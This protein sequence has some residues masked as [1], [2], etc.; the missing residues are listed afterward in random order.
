MGAARNQNKLT[1]DGIGDVDT[2]N[3]GANSHRQSRFGT[4]VSS[5]D[6]QLPGG[7]W[8]IVEPQISVV[9]KSGTSDFHGSA[10]WFHRHEGL[11]ANNWKSNRT[12]SPAG[13]AYNDMAI[14]LAVRFY[15]NHFNRQKNKLFFFF[16]QEY[17]RS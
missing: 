9:T 12:A 4:G 1:I 10:Y 3:N 13:T 5:P 15:P 17:Q 8:E 11:N 2:G 7:V 6:Q 14:Q 16:S